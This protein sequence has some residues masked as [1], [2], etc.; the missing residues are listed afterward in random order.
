MSP[1]LPVAGLLLIFVMIGGPNVYRM[2]TASNRLDESGPP[3]NRV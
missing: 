2:L 3:G 1:P